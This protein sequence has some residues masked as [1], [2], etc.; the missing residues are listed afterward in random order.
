MKVRPIHVLTQ[1]IEMSIVCECGERLTF[2]LN[3]MTDTV[4]DS[5]I[6]IEV[7]PHDCM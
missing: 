5:I 6:D 3:V 7:A 4:G 2:T 1:M